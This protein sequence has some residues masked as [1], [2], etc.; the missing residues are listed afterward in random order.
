MDFK[1]IASVVGL[2]SVISILANVIMGYIEKKKMI[3]FQKRTE[4]KEHRYQCILAFML[5]ILD[6]NNI[7]HVDLSGSKSQI[8]KNMSEEEVKQFFIDEVKAHYVFSHLYASDGVLLKFKEFLNAPSE[9]NYQN[10]A[11]AMRKDLWQ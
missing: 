3:K 9:E 4:E 6:S 7:N 10:V 2:S 5:V 11:R 8:I 1:S